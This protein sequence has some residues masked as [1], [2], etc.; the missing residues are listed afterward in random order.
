MKILNNLKT[1]VKLIGS[2][3]IIAILTGIVGGVG[4]YYLQQIDASYTHVIDNH[5]MGINRLADISVAFQRTRVNLRDILLTPTASG[6]KQYIDTIEELDGE[7]TEKSAEYEK[8]IIS[9]EMRGLFDEY[10]ALYK[11]FGG[12]RDQ[13]IALDQEGKDAEALTVM[14]EDALASAKALEE[15]IEE[16]RALKLKQAEEASTENSAA[17]RQAEVIMFV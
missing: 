4:V 1:S 3:L 12:Y 9:T 5:T 7:I 8:L 17:T 10:S 2:F 13:I 11:E 14:R 6:G 16:M 15:K